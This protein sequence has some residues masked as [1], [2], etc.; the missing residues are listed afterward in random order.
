MSIFSSFNIRT[1]AS[2]QVRAARS[3]SLLMSLLLAAGSAA[4]ATLDGIDYSALPGD[5]VQ[6]RL[7]L[8]EPVV[9]E[10]LSFTIDNPA[11]IAIDLPGTTVGLSEA[12][13]DIGIGSTQ[14]VTAVEADDRTRV[15]VNMSQL[16]P[17]EI[18]AEGS[19]V[20]L[21]LDSV[22]ASLGSDIVAEAATM[23]GSAS[24]AS[25]SDIDFRRG[26]GGEAQILVNLSAPDV[27]INITEQGEDI[28]IDFAETALPEALDRKLD[29]ALHI[30]ARQQ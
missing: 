20:T 30:A 26:P 27:G 22:P 18:S 12:T 24:G 2:A 4:A 16:V 11:R 13:Q 28:I 14:S 17:Y 1:K 6:I 9:G 3:A 5:R 10:P 21:T 7:K 25:I 15:V 29:V 19:M 8:S 23:P